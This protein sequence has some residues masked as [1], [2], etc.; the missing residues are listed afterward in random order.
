[1]LTWFNDTKPAK[2]NANDKKRLA[3]TDHTVKV[4]LVA[5]PFFRAAQA[6][7][8]ATEINNKIMKSKKSTKPVE[9]LEDLWRAFPR[10]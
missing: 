3:Q 1:M 5:R 2:L 8:Q 4:E 9:I 6:T 7:V 10:S